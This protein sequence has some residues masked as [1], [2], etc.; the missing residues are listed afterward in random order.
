M[1]SGATAETPKRRVDEIVGPDIDW[2][3]VGQAMMT[4]VDDEGTSA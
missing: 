3:Q 4:I 1:A 2:I